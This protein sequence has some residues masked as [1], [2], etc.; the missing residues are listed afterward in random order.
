[1]MNYL[2]AVQSRFPAIRPAKFGLYNLATRAVGWRVEPEFRLLERFAPVGTA[3]DVGGN[4]GQSIY[5]LKRT[6]RPASIW[7]FEPNPVLSRRLERAFA[8]DAGVTIQSF[9]LGEAAGTFELFVPRYRDYVYDGLAS[10]DEASARDWLNPQRF[11]GFRA[12]RLSVDRYRVEV[13]TLD[14]FELAPDV[15]KID[16]QGLELAVVKGGW[17]SFR[18]ALPVTIVEAPSPELVDLLRGIG[19]RAYGYA[20]GRLV[21]DDTGGTNTLFLHDDR[22]PPVRDLL[23]G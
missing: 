23:A 8:R 18:R 20:A 13:R 16:V 17:N 6:A 1:M 12:E 14:S 21:P 22:L 2:R 19:M 9:A 3:L 7:S 10:L 15:V 11:A 4:W 5:A